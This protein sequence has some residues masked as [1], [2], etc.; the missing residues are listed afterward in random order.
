MTPLQKLVR[1]QDIEREFSTTEAVHPERA[2]ELHAER[3]VLLAGA[4]RP[5]GELLVRTDPDAWA[6][7]FAERFASTSAEAVIPWFGGAMTA[8][9]SAGRLQGQAEGA[10]S[11]AKAMQH[12]ID[13]SG[14]IL[15]LHDQKRH[16][17]GIVRDNNNPDAPLENVAEILRR[18]LGELGVDTTIAISN[19]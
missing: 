4:H 12:L 14:L 17:L 18:A 3:A 6:Q 5:P 8:A 19:T 2:N 13:V 9:Y 7:A 1:L 15:L 11:G 10:R 16:R